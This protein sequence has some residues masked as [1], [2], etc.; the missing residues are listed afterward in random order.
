MSG[1]FQQNRVSEAI[2]PWQQRGKSQNHLP[3]LSF[4]LLM[5]AI[6][7][8]I[9]SLL[10]FYDHLV[11]ATLAFSISTFVFVASR[12][13]PSLYFA[14]ERIF[15]KLSVVVGTALTW[16]CLVPFFYICFCIGRVSQLLK[17]K[18]PMQRALEPEAKS[19]WQSCKESASVEQYKRQF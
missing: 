7:W 14:I 12:F 10:Y 11:I 4:S 18:D 9:G 5:L 16:I 6:G 19:Y 13:F 3:T 17:K 1:K 15:Q 8:G 2:W